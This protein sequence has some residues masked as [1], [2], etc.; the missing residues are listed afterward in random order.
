M[1]ACLA[2]SAPKSAQEPALPGAPATGP[3]THVTGLKG[4]LL[5]SD[6]DCSMLMDWFRASSWGRRQSPGHIRARGPLVLLPFTH[7][8]Q[9]GPSWSS[10][11]R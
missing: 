4:L 8:A 9:A 2:P 10:P 7:S 3:G 6:C 1:G 11:G 5:R